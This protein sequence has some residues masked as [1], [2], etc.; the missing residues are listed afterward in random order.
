MHI[1]VSFLYILHFVQCCKLKFFAMLSLL[2][3][4][5]WLKYSLE[6]VKIG[7]TKK[8]LCRWH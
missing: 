3:P 8:S 5:E 1:P 4:H 6:V 2:V 7:V